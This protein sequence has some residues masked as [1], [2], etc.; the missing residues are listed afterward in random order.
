V[1]VV[2]AAEA[3]E[4]A[5]DLL[6]LLLLL[7]LM[8]VMVLLAV[9][10]IESSVIDIACFIGG[11]LVVEGGGGEGGGGGGVRTG[12]G[13]AAVDVLRDCWAGGG[14]LL[15]YPLLLVLLLGAFGGEGMGLLLYFLGGEDVRKPAAVV[16][17]VGLCLLCCL[18]AAETVERKTPGGGGLRFFRFSAMLPWP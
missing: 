2:V 15:P 18:S 6:L 1:G 13:M 17:L 16:P 11:R 5:L 7:L 8:S 4:V 10:N 9:T 12:G 3:V 14:D